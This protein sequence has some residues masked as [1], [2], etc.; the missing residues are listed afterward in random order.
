MEYEFLAGGGLAIVIALISIRF[1][2]DRIKRLD[3][4]IMNHIKHN[5]EVLATQ[6]ETNKQLDKQQ[7][8]T[9]YCIHTNTNLKPLLVYSLI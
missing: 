1:F 6:I 5:T 4:L 2:I 8:N 7:E 3:N 9:E